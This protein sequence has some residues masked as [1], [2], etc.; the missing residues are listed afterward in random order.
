MNLSRSAQYKAAEPESL[1]A[2]IGSTADLNEWRLR[3]DAVTA[4]TPILSSSV[5]VRSF[6]PGCLP[7]LRLSTGSRTCCTDPSGPIS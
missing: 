3:L 4:S 2:V 5:I 7:V 6:R 1:V